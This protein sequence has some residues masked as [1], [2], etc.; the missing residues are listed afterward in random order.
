MIGYPDG[1]ANQPFVPWIPGALVNKEVYLFD[2]RMGI[3]LPA[4]DGKGIATVRQIRTSDKP[5]AALTLD[6]KHSYDMT[7]EQA[8][9]MEIFLTVPLSALAPRM[10]FLDDTLGG[11]QKVHSFA[12]WASLLKEFQGAAAAQNIS[13]RFWGANGDRA[14]PIRILRTF[15]PSAE[16]GTDPPPFVLMRQMT[17]QLVPGFSV[18]RVIQEQ[19]LSAGEFGGL[20]ANVFWAPFSEFFM[21]SHG[22]REMVLRGQ[23]D[24]ASTRLT[25]APVTL[26][27]REALFGMLAPLSKEEYQWGRSAR[28]RWRLEALLEGRFV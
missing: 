22:P 23:L 12:D 20:L 21:D 26:R 3:P 27:F 28:R 19:A 10:K 8:R 18:P 15:M 9:K 1:G 16:G 25:Q 11:R 4:P 7:A 5:F 6:D 13:V 2:T 17:L 24:E 14:A